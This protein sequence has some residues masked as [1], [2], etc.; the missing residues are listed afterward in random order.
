MHHAVSPKADANSKESDVL[1]WFNIVW[2]GFP[3][4]KKIT[5]SGYYGFD[6]AGDEAVLYAIINSL[7]KLRADI[8]I[9]VLSNN[10]A[11]TAQLYNVNAV[12]RWKIA[13]V[14]R[15]IRK[16]DLLISGGG[17]LLQDVTSKNSILYYLGVIGIAKFLNKPVFIYSQGIGP[18]N[19]KRNR[20][21]VG[22]ML[23]K[24]HAITVR[25]PQSRQDLI[26]MG[27]KKEITVSV[28]P[29]LAIEPEDVEISHGR[30]LLASANVNNIDG[31]ILGISL[32]PWA[33]DENNF[34]AIAQACDTLAQQGWQI[35]FIPMH[36][37]SDV[38]IAEKIQSLM[39]NPSHVLKENYT[40]YQTLCL[41]KTVDL[42]MGMRLHSLIMAAVL[43]KPM[44]A[45]SYD[46]KVDRFM[47]LLNRPEI[48]PIDN[49]KTQQILD[50]V[51]NTWENRDGFVKHL[52]KTIPPLRTQ[53]LIP[54]RMVVEILGQDFLKR[55]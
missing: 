39:R 22:K 38:Q 14:Y 18:V 48:L 51:Q 8:Q 4:M 46:P 32:R 21:L 52:K 54:A 13:E 50:L 33:T 42:V 25:D 16:S 41:Y 12:N 10:P 44:I 55:N 43:E 1:L 19:Y 24:V 17:S 30:E 6:N 7:R 3:I 11:H 49:L 31:K 53:A 34:Q 45:I 28:D 5:L 35:I 15:A 9:T 37:P 40:P 23:N 26:D 27:V 2:R 36:F 47:E 29:V 20:L